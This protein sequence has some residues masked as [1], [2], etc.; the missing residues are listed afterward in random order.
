MWNGSQAQVLALLW[1]SS[2]IRG[3]ITVD[4]LLRGP[5]G[6]GLTLVA[7][8][9]D[10]RAAE[11]VTIVDD[12]EELRGARAG[13]VA[14]LTRHASSLAAG[15]RLDVALRLA[16]EHELAAL[17]VFGE[18]TTSVTA[19]RLA[20]RARI[21]LL[22]IAPDRDL[23]EL[24]FGLDHAI[25]QDAGAVLGRALAAL[26]AIEA[27]ERHGSDAVLA[28]A[29]AALGA[30]LEV[31]ASAE[32]GEPIV[33]DGRTEGHVATDARDGATRLATRLAAD[34]LGRVRSAERR[35]QRTPARARSEALAELLLAPR[36]RVAERAERARDLGVPVDG[37]HRAV[38][39]EIPSGAHGVDEALEDA[40]LA[41]APPGTWHTTRIEGALVLVHSVDA[42]RPDDHA[43]VDAMLAAV[44]GP[45]LHC[46]VGHR[47]E[48][49]EGLRAS[50]AEAETAAV[51]ARTLGRENVAL[52]ID[53]VGL[54]PML[55]DWLASDAAQESVSRL[56]APLDA[57]G[58][59]RA[60]TAVRT[61]QV[62][63]D[64]RGSLQRSA[65]RLHLHRN[66]VAYRMRRIA[67]RLDVDLDDPDARLTLQLACRA[68]LLRADE[69]G[70]P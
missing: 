37:W 51:A 29:R 50:A 63:L 6:R 18:A 26:E 5:E 38:R 41:S 20:T 4:R 32:G 2:T 8:P 30:P 1:S 48:G 10:A 61:L 17:A 49:P 62:Y 45:T 19:I 68:R 16:G 14:L 39:V 12:L 35:A 59:R 21:A 24:A 55:L 15:Y 70:A 53:A 69:R 27:A 3:V 23:S 47:H 28:A 43:D 56:L 44:D 66:A 9:W 52:G 11:A 42:D 67:E 25:R 34:A 65:A 57:L 40:L 22:A 58:P 60:L 46:G 64:E 54:P 33:V 31:R 36:R 13:A 7:G